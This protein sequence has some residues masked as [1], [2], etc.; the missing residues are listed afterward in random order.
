VIADGAG[1][2]GRNLEYLAGLTLGLGGAP[3]IYAL[4][5]DT[6]GLDGNADHAGAM[7]V[8]ETLARGGA[9]GLS[10]AGLLA[11]SDSYRWF[12]ACNLLLKPGPTRTNV[13]DF[14]LI[15]CIP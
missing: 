14:R 5:V 8:P 11:A 3:G 13:N 7:V 15:L 9:A 6:D 12:D 2:G 10:L 4:A 1:R